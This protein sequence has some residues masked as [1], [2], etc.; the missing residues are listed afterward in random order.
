M[1]RKPSKEFVANMKMFR[2]EQI[3]QALVD[4]EALLAD[5]F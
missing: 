4:E 3:M 1:N 2:L 5:G